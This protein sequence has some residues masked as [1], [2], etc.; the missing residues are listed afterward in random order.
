MQRKKY[1]LEPLA[2]LKRERAE[3]R[4]RELGEAVAAREAL[5]KERAAKE[6]DRERARDAASVVCREE[7]ARLEG[8]D[9]KVLD[10]VRGGIW[11]TRVKTEDAQRGRAIERARAAEEEARATEA[12]AKLHVASAKAESESVQRHHARWDALAK[13]AEEAREEEA[14]S[15]AVRPKRKP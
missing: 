8:G 1:P 14:M 9:L 2:R 12:G 4:T 13:N 15:E 3:T 6:A 7:R 11:E 5:E 10:L